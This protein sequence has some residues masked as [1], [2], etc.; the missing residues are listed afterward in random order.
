M[1]FRIGLI[2]DSLGLLFTESF[3]NEYPAL[4]CLNAKFG[5]YFGVYFVGNSDFT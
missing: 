2:T 4:H 3:T 1:F 5:I